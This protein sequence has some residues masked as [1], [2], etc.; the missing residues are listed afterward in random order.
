MML[1]KEFQNVIPD[2]NF[3]NYYEMWLYHEQCQIKLNC[4]HCK[5]CLNCLELD[6]IN[7]YIDNI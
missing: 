4:F 5:N 3:I 6:R 7:Y 1:I 2:Y